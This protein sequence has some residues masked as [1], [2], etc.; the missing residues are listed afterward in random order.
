MRGRNA[1]ASVIT[2][3]VSGLPTTKVNQAF[4]LNRGFGRTSVRRQNFLQLP[5][6]FVRHYL[7]LQ[8]NLTELYVHQ[9]LRYCLKFRQ[10]AH[11]NI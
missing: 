1:S 8:A 5:Q 7:F 10:Y 3:K 2:L 4:H 11:L 6:M 9:L